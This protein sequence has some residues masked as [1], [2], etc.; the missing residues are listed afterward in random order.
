MFD[1]C[2][3]LTCNVFCNVLCLCV[4]SFCHCLSTE[5][6][7]VPTVLTHHPTTSRGSDVPQA[8]QWDDKAG[9]EITLHWLYIL[10]I[11]P[12]RMIVIVRE[13]LPQNHFILYYFCYY[14]LLIYIGHICFQFW[15]VFSAVSHSLTLY[16]TQHLMKFDTIGEPG[17]S[18]LICMLTLVDISGQHS[19]WV[20]LT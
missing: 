7:A 6:P 4:M 1:S 8:T 2:P 5:Q 12:A 17:Q 19:A 18:L 11:L 10:Y 3:T 14:N 15:V 9:E 13:P 20:H 16:V